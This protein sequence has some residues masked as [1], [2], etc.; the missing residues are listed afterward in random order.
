ML[1]LSPDSDLEI[2]SETLNSSHSSMS[3]AGSCDR[4]SSFSRL[5]F[6]A[7]AAAAASPSPPT[8]RAGAKP[9]RASDPAWAAI[10]RG[11]PPRRR[12]G[13]AAPAR[14]LYAMKVVDKM[15]IAKKK[16]LERAATERRILR[17]LD[18]PFLPSL[19][20]DFDASPHYSCVVMEYCCGG[21]LHSLRHRQPALRFSLSAA[22]LGALQVLRGGGAVGVGVPAHAGDRVPRPEA[23]EH[24]DPID[25]HIML[26]DFD[27]SLVSTS[28]PTVERVG[29][30]TTTTT[31][32]TPT[33]TRPPPLLTQHPP[34]PP[35]PPRPGPLVPPRPALPVQEAPRA[36]PPV[37]G[38]AGR[39]PVRVLRG[40]PRVRGPRGRLRRAPRQRRRLVGLRRPPLRAPLRPHPLR[41]AHHRR[42]P[43]Q[44]RAPA[45][46][47]PRPSPSPTPTPTP[48]GPPGSA[49]A[50]DLIA[51]LLVKDPTARLGSRR[52][53]ADVKSHPFFKGLNFALLRTH[54]PPVVP[55]P[56]GPPPPT[57][58]IDR[59]GSTFSK[60]PSPTTPPASYSYCP[61][62]NGNVAA[63]GCYSDTASSSSTPVAL[64]GWQLTLDALDTL[65]SLGHV[66]NQTMQSE[67]AASLYK[68]DHV[69]PNHKLVTRHS[70]SKSHGK[71]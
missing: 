61:W 45:P 47:L 53:A 44:H 71:R 41:G 20:A 4:C 21:D 70:A 18:H 67:S 59:P 26:S 25:G 33:T 28:S 43:P 6:D 55:G 3:S 31:T 13:G 57:T 22:S 58:A 66:P 9:H 64:C 37:R 16:K 10:R 39:G 24:P 15:A 62:V 14:F 17:V 51:R 7:S 69:T 5:S 34:T 65:Q 35:T 50:R 54:R 30:T 40:D 23:G 27:L 52:G 48:T 36:R 12:R 56:A 60:P 63:A 8:P 29:P 42:H 11:A 49:A 68:D 32:T 1:E 46:R 2:G 38:R 19:Y